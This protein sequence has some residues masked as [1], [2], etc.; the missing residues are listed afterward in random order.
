[1][2]VEATFHKNA[3]IKNLVILFDFFCAVEPIYS[4]FFKP[5]GFFD[6]IWMFLLEDIWNNYLTLCQFGYFLS[7]ILYRFWDIWIQGFNGLTLT[8]DFWPLEVS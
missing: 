6:L 8:F 2:S 3:L 4:F 7:R 1:M 5:I